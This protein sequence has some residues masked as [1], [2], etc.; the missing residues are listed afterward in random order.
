M[1]EAEPELREAVIGIC[2]SILLAQTD[3]PLRVIAV[4]S[5]LPGEG[6][7][8]VARLLGQALAESGGKT[9]LVDADLRISDL[10]EVYGG[11]MQDGLSMLLSGNAPKPAIRETTVPNLYVLPSGPKPPNSVALLNSEAMTEF[12]KSAKAGFQYVV[13]DT[14]PVLGIADS[15][16]LAARVDGVVLVVRGA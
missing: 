7:T 14:P 4:T 5:S 8:T 9:L 10:S 6:K 12:L 11:R 1:G 16:V 2:T 13:V 3:Q 15:R